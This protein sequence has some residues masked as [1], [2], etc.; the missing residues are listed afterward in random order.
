[1]GHYKCFIRDFD[2]NDGSGRPKRDQNRNVEA[3]NNKEGHS[4]KE[5]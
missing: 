1:M 3:L 5:S 2:L 4:Y